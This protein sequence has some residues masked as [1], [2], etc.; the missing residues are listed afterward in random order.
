MSSGGLRLFRP[1]RRAPRIYLH[2]GAMKTGTTFLQDLMT[3]NKEA[4]AAAGFLFPGERRTDQS[5]AVRDVLGFAITDPLGPSGSTGMWD[6]I[7][8]QMLAYDGTASILSMEFLSYADTERATRIVESLRDAEVHVVLTVR[9]AAATIPAQWQTSCRNG[10]KVTLRRFVQ[11]VGDLLDDENGT[12]GGDSDGHGASDGGSAGDGGSGGAVGGSGGRIFQRTQ[13]VVRMLDVWV[14]L[15]G[16]KRVHVVTVPP[17]G[18][19]PEILWH[20]FAS[21]VGLDPSVCRDR[22]VDPNPSLGHASTE[23]VR[24]VNGELGKVDYFDYVRTVKRQLARGILGSRAPLESQVR[25]NR[26]GHRFAAQWNDRVRQAVERHGVRLVGTFDDLPVA[27]PGPEVPKPMPSPSTEELLEAAATAIDGLRHWT[28]MLTRALAEGVRTHAFR[29][30]T[31][32]F[33]DPRAIDPAD[34]TSPDRW[35]GE[36]EPVDA[37]VREVVSL[38]RTCMELRE[39]VQ[40]LDSHALSSRSAASG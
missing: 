15:V 39:Q 21:V 11:G 18:S 31:H 19:D 4:M 8:R 5:R 37:A 16:R 24:L 29:A 40:A 17:R 30:I 14:P 1:G 38:V 9:D 22:T 34:A 33:A 13:G 6:V 3:A 20:R 7:S 26:K 10:A 12:G 25:L 2:I 35:A 27:P 23:L 32:E 36:P 28:Q